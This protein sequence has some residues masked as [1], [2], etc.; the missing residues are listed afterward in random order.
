VTLVASSALKYPVLSEITQDAGVSQG[1]SQY[2]H[3][4]AGWKL[5]H[6]PSPFLLMPM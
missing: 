3:S 2:V 6:S 5:D 1:L 4:N